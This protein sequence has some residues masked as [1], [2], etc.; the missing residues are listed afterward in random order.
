[1]FKERK[2]KALYIEPCGEN[3]TR[4][5]WF[6]EAVGYRADN[7]SRNS[8]LLPLDKSSEHDNALFLPA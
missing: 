7:L 8:G 2:I 1:L 4:L 3:G 5:C 6:M